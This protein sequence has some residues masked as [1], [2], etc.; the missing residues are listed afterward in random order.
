MDKPKM[1]EM[2]QIDEEDKQW[3]HY[4][5][6]TSDLVEWV[7]SYAREQV[8]AHHAAWEAKLAEVEA[9]RDALRRDA[10]RFAWWFSADAKRV[11]IHEYLRGCGE[12]WSLDQWRTFVDSSMQEVAN[13]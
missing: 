11:N 12:G 10:G 13:D 4:S 9:E 8:A 6:N 1:P 2:R 5:P 7:E 3:L